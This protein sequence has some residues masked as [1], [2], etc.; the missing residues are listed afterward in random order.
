MSTNLKAI[1]KGVGN[2]LLVLFI[3]NLIYLGIALIQTE[4]SAIARMGFK[5]VA[6]SINNKI[7]GLEIG[8]FKANA[9]LILVFSTV[10]YTEYQKGNVHFKKIKQI[11]KK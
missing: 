8:N 9:I 7:I 1:L 11:K 4:F 3:I 10:I 2:A 6:F 5:N